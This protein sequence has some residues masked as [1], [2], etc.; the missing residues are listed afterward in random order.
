MSMQTPPFRIERT[1][2]RHS[3]ALLREN[4]IIIRLARDLSI[5]EEHEHIASL[6]K[7]MIRIASKEVARTVIDPFRPLLDGTTD[8][9][10]LSLATGTT[11]VFRMTAGRRTQAKHINDGWQVIVGPA[12]QSRALHRFLWKLLSIAALPPLKTYVHAVDRE[13]LN[14]HIGEIRIRTMSSQWG[15][16]ST[17]GTITLTTA[18]LLLPEELLRYVT[19]HELA[20]R[21]HPHHSHTFWAEVETAC[22]AFPAA[23]KHLRSFR[24]PAL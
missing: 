5:R 7:R 18:L 14:V 11:V 9:L 15:S 13:T 10:T 6:L 24:L 4:V 23:R 1:R 16:C 2:N 21:L 19:I 22:P 17:R 3:R 8:A 20:H 12:L